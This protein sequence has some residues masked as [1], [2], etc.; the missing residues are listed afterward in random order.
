MG[1]VESIAFVRSRQPTEDQQRDM[2]RRVLDR[3]P[4]MDKARFIAD[5]QVPWLRLIG[6]L[7]LVEQ[8]EGSRLVQL[9][10]SGVRDEAVYQIEGGVTQMPLAP[11]EA[12]SFLIGK[13]PR[14]I[15]RGYEDGDL[16]LRLR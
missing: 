12:L 5:M 6:R 15:N 10:R 3:M 2:A 4:P 8:I 1:T 16:S 9:W 13:S 11:G 7:D 14:R